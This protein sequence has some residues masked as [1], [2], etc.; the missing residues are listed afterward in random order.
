MREF[1]TSRFP[2]FL[3]PLLR[4]GLVLPLLA[5]AFLGGQTSDEDL[6]AH[7]SR[8]QRAEARQDFATA[9]SEYQI[10]VRA[11]PTN[12]ELESNLGVALYFHRDFSQAAEAMRRA[13]HLKPELYAPHLFLGLAMAQLSRPDAAVPELE[14]AIA[15]NSADPLAHTWLGYEYT[16][17]SRFEKAAAQFEIAA[18]EKPGDQ[19]VWF[20]LGRCYLELGKAATAELTVSYPDGGRVWQLAAEQYEAQGK[21]DKALSF[22]A[23]ALERRPGIESLQQKILAL[24]G[25]VPTTKPGPAASH[26]PEDQLYDSVEQYETKSR[27]AFERVSQIDPNSYRAHQVL[28]ESHVA[29]NNYDAAIA[30]YRAVLEQKSDLPGIHGELCNALSRVAKIQEAIAECDAELAVSPYSAD[31]YVQAARVRLLAGDDARAAVLLD[32]GLKLDR[33][34]IVA[35]KLLA[36]VT[37]ARRQYPETIAALTRYLSVETKDSSAYY[38]LARAYKAAGNPEKMNRAIADYK[39]TSAFAESQGQ[40][41]RALDS[42]RDEDAAAEIKKEEQNPF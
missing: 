6:A 31:A 42:N 38:L 18:E 5:S 21:R 20:A 14:K 17:Q 34:P 25:A 19:D 11:L 1:L 26:A 15:L 7:Q 8:A 28:A 22:Y 10:L 13:I 41:P 35:Y 12:A 37:F 9:V 29:A 4:I 3:N 36:K 27:S 40:A 2:G 32:Q 23:G 16:A 33:P 30:E 24:G 39:R